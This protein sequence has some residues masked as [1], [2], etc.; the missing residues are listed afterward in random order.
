MNIVLNPG[1]EKI[2]NEAVNWFLNS[3]EQLFEI[4]NKIYS[5][6]INPFTGDAKPNYDF[7]IVIDEDPTLTDVFST[8]FMNLT[9]DEIKKYEQLF[10]IQ[11]L[12][13]KDHQIIYQSSLEVKTY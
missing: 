12:V 9:I 11:T 8:V 5:H 10:D 13:S 1:Q 6:I 3:S 2:K 4:D 7:V